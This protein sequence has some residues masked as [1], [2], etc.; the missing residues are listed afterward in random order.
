MFF[1]NAIWDEIICKLPHFEQLDE[2][3]INKLK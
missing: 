3:T 1:A 2:I